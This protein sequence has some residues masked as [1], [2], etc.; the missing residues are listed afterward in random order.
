MPGKAAEAGQI[1]FD[2]D[3]TPGHFSRMEVMLRP[4]QW[5]IVGSLKADMLYREGEWSPSAQLRLSEAEGRRWIGIGLTA[6]VP[7]KKIVREGASVT[8]AIIRKAGDG[9]PSQETLGSLPLGQA[10]PFEIALDGEHLTIKLAGTTRVMDVKLNGARKIE[11]GC[12]TGDFK[13]IDILAR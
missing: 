13:F 2:C 3:A 12:S 8:I 10:L 7:T 9:T 1:Y 6:S 11:L 4:E 5:S